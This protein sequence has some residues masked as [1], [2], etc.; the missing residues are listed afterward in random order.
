MGK[1]ELFTIK[2]EAEDCDESINV[3]LAVGCQETTDTLMKCIGKE[4][5]YCDY[6]QDISDALKPCLDKITKS[7]IEFMNNN[8]INGSFD[9]KD[10]LMNLLNMLREKDK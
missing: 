8:L 2:C 5:E 3:G 6:I 9:Q 7:T 1:L 10:A 4:K